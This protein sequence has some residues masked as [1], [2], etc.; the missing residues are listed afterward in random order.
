MSFLILTAGLASGVAIALFAIMWARRQSSSRKSGPA[1]SGSDVIWDLGGRNRR[2]PEGT[3]TK[4]ERRRFLGSLGASAIALIVVQLDA[5]GISSK[6]LRDLFRNANGSSLQPPPETQV[7]LAAQFQDHGD[8]HD[9]PHSDYPHNDTPSHH[10]DVNS[11]VG[12]E[13]TES[14]H[15]D[16]HTDVSHYDS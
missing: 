7:A 15:M 2:Q 14:P 13:D 9:T 12:H 1:S 11:E 5:R 8:H 10:L 4:L 6:K 16:S 3:N